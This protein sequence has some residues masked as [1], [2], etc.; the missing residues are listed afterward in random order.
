VIDLEAALTDLADHLDYPAGDDLTAAVVR[1]I[2]APASERE[3]RSLPRTR[4]LLV[5]AAAVVL[6]LGALLAIAPARH[7]IADWLGI[8]AVEVVRTEKPPATGPPA[9]TVPGATDAPP[10]GAV[11]QRLA[12]AQKAAAF[13][14]LR[15]HA[16]TA[17]ALLGIDTDSRVPGGLVALRYKRFTLVEIASTRNGA[18]VGKFI[19]PNAR[20]ESVPV[21]GNPGLWVT[22]AHEIGYLNRAGRV[23]TGTVR[24]SGPVL[25]W[26]RAGVTYR[27]EGIPG[28]IE[29]QSIAS[30]IR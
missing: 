11:A 22:G 7:A 5:V 25:L 26:A 19:D 14:I 8:G 6:I 15:P 4:A 18:T 29:A 10:S 24:R 21:A 27:I 17:G 13:T 16:A 3:H 1:R 30:T 12:A 9:S 28:L 2:S 23:E 20:V